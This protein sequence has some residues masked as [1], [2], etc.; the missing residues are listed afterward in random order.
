MVCAFKLLQ[1]DPDRQGHEIQQ[2]TLQVVQG[3]MQL[4][5]QDAHADVAML[6]SQALL[7]LHKPENVE[8]WNREAPIATFWDIR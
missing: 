3:L 5:C 1:Q 7:T 6:A 2:S 4:M 8:L